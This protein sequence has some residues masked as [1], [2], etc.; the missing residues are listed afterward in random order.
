MWYINTYRDFLSE[1]TSRHHTVGSSLTILAVISVLLTVLA[2]R[3]RRTSEAPPR[4]G[5]C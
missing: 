4:F 5:F 2:R 1:N 3:E